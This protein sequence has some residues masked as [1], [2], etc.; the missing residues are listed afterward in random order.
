MR[1]ERLHRWQ[2]IFMGLVIG[3][4]VAYVRQMY[5]DDVLSDYGNTMN[6]AEQFELSL[7][8]DYKG[9]RLFKDLVIYPIKLR[10]EQ[11]FLVA[12]K[13]YPGRPE[14]QANGKI[15]A[16]W[17]PYCFIQEKPVYKP[18]NKLEKL[19][20]PGGPDYALQW[21]AI[22]NPSLLDFM[23]IMREAK[24]INFRYAWWA[25]PKKS[26]SLWMGT[27][28]LVIGGIW[29]FLVNLIA[30]GSLKA[31]PE[32]K[33]INLRKVKPTATAASEVKVP[34]S[35]MTVQDMDQVELLASQLES[36]LAKAAADEPDDAAAAAAAAPTTGPAP[37]KQLTATVNER[38]AGFDDHRDDK[39]F[40]ANADDFYP[41]ERKATKP[42]EP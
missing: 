40:G 36:N 27:G 9:V 15:A 29:P 24:G 22:T 34:K 13:F 7:S 32:E 21:K 3:L 28:V 42:H 4:I 37:I 38:A 25:E 17:R 39:S 6:T 26:F 2:W 11:R 31:P 30:F 33:G 10:G 14:R 12:G 1:L 23:N 20:K 35:A 8:Q 41:T 19:N 5:T 18:F 16:I